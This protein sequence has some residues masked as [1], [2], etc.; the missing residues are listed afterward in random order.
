[1]NYRPLG[2]S[3]IRA[4]VVGLGTWAIGGWMWGGTDEAAS[5][6]AIRASIDAGVNLIDTAPA[7][8]QGLCETIVGK[9]IHGRRDRVVLA[10]KCGLRWDPNFRGGELLHEDKQT[11]LKIHKYLHPDSIR[12]ELEQS[13]TRLNTDYID[14]Y[15]TH[16]QDPTTP[17]EDTMAC[18][19]DLK[20]EGKIRAIGVSNATP[21][22]IDEY[23]RL[24]PVDVDQEK[25]S[26]LDRKLEPTNI[27]YCNDH[28]IAF[29]AYSPMAMGL[30]TGKVAPDRQ[31][32]P[33]D[34]RSRQPRFSADNRR[35]VLAMLEEFKPIADAH[36]CTLAQLVVA[37]TLAQPGATHALV[38]AR[39]PQQADENIVAGELHLRE[40]ELRQMSIILAKHAPGIV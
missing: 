34:V 11:G 12:H 15:Q 21:G 30:L 19:L 20:K 40:N 1:M 3:N 24:G 29:L 18:L 36:H 6:D 38:G 33:D 7:Y 17:I 28:H 31:F 4:S 9:A 37:W 32:P 14:L 10:T 5:I 13:L 22:M 26:M 16:W 25:F 23:R 35:R 2:Q 8:G 39:N 27:N